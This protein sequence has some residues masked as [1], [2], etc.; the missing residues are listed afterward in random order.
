MLTMMLSRNLMSTLQLSFIIWQIGRTA[1]HIA[2][3]KGS[4]EMVKAL[5][6]GGADVGAPDN[7]S[8][9]IISRIFQT[10]SVQTQ[11]T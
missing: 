9:I 5:L 7:V 8:C 6:D 11:M 1:L 2:S 4:I 3:R 10:P